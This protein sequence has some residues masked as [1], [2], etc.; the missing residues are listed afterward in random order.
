MK[1]VQRLRKKTSLALTNPQ[2]V[3]AVVDIS[4]SVTNAW[5]E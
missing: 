1:Y 4:A 3:A 2:H 5:L